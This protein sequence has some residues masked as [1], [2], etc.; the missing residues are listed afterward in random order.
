[1]LSAF[2]M[3]FPFFLK[4]SNWQLAINK[5]QIILLA[6]LYFTKSTAMAQMAN[7]SGIIMFG[8]VPITQANIILEKANL[9]TSTNIS[10]KYQINN[11][12][13]GTYRIQVSHIGF[14]PIIDSL[15]IES[16]QSQIKN[17]TLDYAETRVPY[18]MK[19]FIQELE[20]MGI[21]SRLQMNN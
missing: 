14:M 8:D 11:I 15:T 3:C 2:I 21:A 7:L 6:L 13:N 5:N 9:G 19:L 10:G 16:G 4:Y 17:F 18:A 12:P 20:A 1:M